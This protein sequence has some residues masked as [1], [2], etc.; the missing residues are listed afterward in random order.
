MLKN[1]LLAGVMCLPGVS[2]RK[3]ATGRLP[4]KMKYVCHFCANLS[5]STL[6]VVT[7]FL[8][9]CHT[10]NFNHVCAFMYTYLYQPVNYQVIHLSLRFFT[11]SPTSSS[12]VRRCILK[13]KVVTVTNAACSNY[14]NEQR[15][16]VILNHR[17]LQALDPPLHL[18]G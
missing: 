18:G 2:H 10:F 7:L 4:R 12:H 5:G 15:A 13:V 14:V 1:T 16:I 6:L 9:Y 8:C 17:F 11:Y 3:I